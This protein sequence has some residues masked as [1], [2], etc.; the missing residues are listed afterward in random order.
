[1]PRAPAA[2]PGVSFQRVA[3]VAAIVFAVLA[4]YAPVRNYPFINLDDNEYVTDNPFVRTGLSGENVEWA[5]T[6]FHSGHWHPL[7]WLS[8]MADCQWSGTAPGALHLVNA[9]LGA[10]AAALLFLWVESATGCF[11]R[12]AFVAALFALHPLRVESIAWVAARKDVLSGLFLMLAVWAWVAYAKN[13][14]LR[15]YLL[16]MLAFALALLAKPTVA[17]LPCGLLLLDFWPLRRRSFPGLRGAASIAVNPREVPVGWLIAEKLPLVALA[18]LT[19][20]QTWAAQHAAGAVMQGYLPFPTRV[21]NTFWHYALYLDRTFR[22]LDLAVFYPLQK[23][24]SANAVASALG[25]VLVTILAWRV[26]GKLP[27]V[28]VGWLWFVGTLLPE[29]G[30]IQFGGQAIADRYSYI[31][32]IGLFLMLTWGAA[33]LFERWQVPRAAIA[34]VAVLLLGGLAARTSDQLGYWSSSVALFERAIAVTDGNYMAHNNLGVALDDLGREED[35]AKHYAEAVRINPTW[36][37]ALNNYG[38]AL[39][40]RGQFGEARSRFEE[41]LRIRPA[42]AKAENNLGT[43]YGREQ[44]FDEAIVHYTRALDLDGSYFD[45]R[46]ALGDALERRGRFRAAEV[47]Y[48]EALAL[49]PGFAPA[50]AALARVQAGIAAATGQPPQL[51]IGSAR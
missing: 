51:G 50:A 30:I 40:R 48:R 39:A 1:M 12:S 43:T 21:A 37:E 20:R 33:D 17:I 38:I 25:L 5:L 9:L 32:H 22:P 44:N 41:A 42:F 34:G 35:A 26:R 49:R 28:L 10:A 4:L 13:P 23:V 19:L 29:S 7:T 47:Q 45:A 8:L 11:W 3:V 6:A 27:Y 18:A 16:T 15:R 14:S 2:R 31:P 46:Y 36:P 24:P